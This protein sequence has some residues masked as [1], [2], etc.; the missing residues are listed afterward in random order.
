MMKNRAMECR[1]V[2]GS[3]MLVFHGAKA[4]SDRTTQQRI[5][6]KSGYWYRDPI[7]SSSLES[8]AP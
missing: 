8:P 3:V 2:N 5:I 1:A 4:L 7:S 6:K